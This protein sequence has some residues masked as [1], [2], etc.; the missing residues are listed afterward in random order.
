MQNSEN[1]GRTKMEKHGLLLD[2]DRCVGCHAC[3]VGCKQWH[4]VPGDE[5][6]IRVKTIGPKKL[7]DMLREDFFVEVNGGC[8]LCESRVQENLD[9]F[10][11]ATCPTKALMLCN[12]TEILSLLASPKRYQIC[13]LEGA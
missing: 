11:V 13:R 6:W 12:S 2:M 7:G 4:A 9:P 5:K 10:C 8:N 3:E 1:L